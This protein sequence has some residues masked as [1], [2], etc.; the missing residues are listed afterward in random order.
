MAA[1]AWPLQQAVYQRL[2]ADPDLTAMC[3][4]YDEVPEP[5][6]YPHVSVGEV[7]EE[8]DDT[9]DNQGLSVAFVLH[10]WSKYR[11]FGEVGRVLAHLDRL[12]DRQ[13]LAVPGFEVVAFFREH[14]RVVRDPDPTIRHC[15]VRYRVWLNKET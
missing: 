5:A 7:V 11:G 1:A 10:I 6:P 4:V 9:H 3:G 8:P 15:P 13:P 14:H 2:I 12:L